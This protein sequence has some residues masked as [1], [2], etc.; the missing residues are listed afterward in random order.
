MKEN[1]LQR[2]LRPHRKQIEDLDARIVALIS[3]RA[4]QSVQI[5]KVKGELTEHVLDPVQEKEVYKRIARLNEGPLPDSALQAIYREI[6]SGSLALQKTL[7]V[8]YLGPEA[9]FTHQAAM[10]KFGR[11]VEYLATNSIG[12][13]FYEVETER[14]D[15][16]VVPIENSTDG[17]VNRTLDM[18]IDADLKICSEIVFEI[19]HCLMA[20][21]PQNQIKKVFSKGEVF[22]QCKLWLRAN[23]PRA[24]YIE[25]SSTSRAAQLASEEPG[26]AAIASEIAASL[27]ALRVV[28]RSIQ[29]TTR[30]LTRFLVIGKS[31]SPKSGD[32][33]TSV[34]FYTKDRVGALHDVL[35]IFKEERINLTMIESRPS[36]K[37]LF[38]YYFFADFAGHVTDAKIAST[39]KKLKKK[40]GVLKVLGSYPRSS[41]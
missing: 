3:E 30:N 26:A 38:E 28:A 31:E 4:K 21:C 36:G 22:G 33:K 16:G 8:A 5:G 24:E 34:M 40:C 29:D 12:D 41:Q 27:Y 19:S 2:R 25:V 7:K 39:L 20:K 10:S 14:A 32:D 17:A 9:T 15:H 35:Q 23:F 13:V 18:F 6:M 1:E 37:K 11:S